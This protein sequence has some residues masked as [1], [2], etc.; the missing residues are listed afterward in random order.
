MLK[1]L[2]FFIVN[3]FFQVDKYACGYGLGTSDA[4]PDEEKLVIFVRGY[5]VLGVPFEVALSDKAITNMAEWVQ[6]KEKYI[7][8]LKEEG[9]MPV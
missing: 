6:H 1:R 7:K 2:W 9:E 3:R 8:Q 4:C 5:S